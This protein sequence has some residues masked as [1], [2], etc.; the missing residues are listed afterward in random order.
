MNNS[1]FKSIHSALS[2]ENNFDIDQVKHVEE[3]NEDS[4]ELRHQMPHL[5]VPNS[6]KRKLPSDRLMNGS[7]PS[8]SIASPRAKKRGKWGEYEDR[9]LHGLASKFVERKEKINFKK[10]ANQLPGR[11]AKQCRE[12]WLSTLNP[13]LKKGRWTKVEEIN[14]LD[15]MT[16]HGKSWSIIAKQ[17]PGRA[18]HSVKAKGR[19]MLGER[20]KSIPQSA[21]NYSATEE[22]KQKLFMLHQQL[23]SDFDEISKQSGFIVSPA[24]IERTML[25]MCTCQTCVDLVDRIKDTNSTNLLHGWTKIKAEEIKNKL[26]KKSNKYS[27]PELFGA[28]NPQ[29]ETSADRKSVV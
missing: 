4:N 18:E 26:L 16:A 25:G 2:A 9:V 12:H 7:S 10:I 23:G 11:T 14:L 5:G 15:L 27:S 19:L 24:K 13:D 22:Q 29:A 6:L 17:I 28:V 8:G 3:V 21:V 1:S 20:L